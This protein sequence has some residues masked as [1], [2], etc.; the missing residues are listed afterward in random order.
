MLTKRYLKN[1]KE[2]YHLGS[3]GV[4]EIKMQTRQSLRM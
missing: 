3:L 2:L 4:D 1:V